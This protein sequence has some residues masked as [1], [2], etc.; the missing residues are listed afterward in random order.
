MERK[1][2]NKAAALGSAPYKLNV[3]PTGILALDY[4]LG[5]GGWPLGHPVEIFGAP[6]IGKSSVL[7]LSALR[8]AQAMDLTCGIVALEP[9]F[10][11]EWAIKNGVDPEWLIIGR[12]DDGQAA[13]EMLYDWVTDDLVD[14]ILF[15]SIGALLRP[16][17]TE[18]KGKPSQGGQSNLITWGVKR[19]LMPAWKNNKGVIFLNQVRDDMN[20]RMPGMV[21][22]PGGW[23]LKHSAAVRVHL[24]QGK[25]KETESV[26]TGDEK[27]D[28]I[29]GRQL[30]ASIKRNKLSEGT[31]RKA[32]FWYFQ[33]ET[34]GS[35]VGLDSASDVLGTALRTG[36]IKKQGWYHYPA[37]PEDKKGE[38]K[39]QSKEKVAEFL[40]ENP[41]VVA[42]IREEVLAVMLKKAGAP[43]ELQPE[44]DEPQG[45]ED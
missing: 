16:S 22:S 4:A 5:T 31:N 23:A 40:D 3:V 45:D 36:V 12:P 38:H 20:A 17:E 33:K 35:P 30:V 1:Y 43:K 18:D 34:E 13:F 9:S 28:I 10:D 44:P 2:G 19:I 14:F 8:N 39:I 26:G 25:N 37:F 41:E 11:K 7:G 42:Q 15:D 6:D 21:E 32:T 24:K 27:E 29:I